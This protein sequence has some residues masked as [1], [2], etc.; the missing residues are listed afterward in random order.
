M[1]N[2]DLEPSWVYFLGSHTQ[3]QPSMCTSSL[4]ARL[5]RNRLQGG[6]SI[7]Y[8]V[9]VLLVYA[10]DNC[11]GCVDLSYSYLKLRINS[12]ALLEMYEKLV[13]AL[14]SHYRRSIDTLLPSLFIILLFF[15]VYYMAYNAARV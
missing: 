2:N 10:T 5:L 12:A 3:G 15:T 9:I 14:Y 13:V 6:N 1:F 8:L 4:K 7:S 11:C